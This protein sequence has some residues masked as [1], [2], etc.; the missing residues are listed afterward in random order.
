MSK[1]SETYLIGYDQSGKSEYACLTI[2]KRVDK[3]RLVV[4]NTFLGK[5][6][7][8]LHNKLVFNNPNAH[9]I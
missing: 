1:I 2:V 3:D 6:A 9:N 5:E 7:E 8:E 4:V